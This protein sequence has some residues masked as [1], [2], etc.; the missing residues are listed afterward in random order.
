MRASTTHNTT[1]QILSTELANLTSTAAVNPPNLSNLRRNIRHQRQEQN[2]LLNPPRKEDAPVFPHEYQMTGTGERFFRFDSGAR[3]IYRMFI[4]ATNDGIDMLANS[5]QWFGDGTFKLWPQIFSQIYAIHALTNH[6][7]LPCVFGLLPSKAKIVYMQFF[8]TVCNTVRNNN[9]NDPEGFLVDFETASTNAIKNVLPQMD[10]SSCFF[11]LSSKFW[12]DKQRAGL[13]ERYMNDP[14][15]GL[16]LCVIAAL[17]FVPLQDV[18]NSFDALCIFIRNQYDRDTDE[19]LDYFENTYIGRFL[20]NAPRR[21]PLFPIELWNR[22]HR[23]AEELPRTNNNIE[24]W[25]NSLQANVSFTH[26]TFWK[27]L[28]VL[29]RK[30][31]IVQVKMLQNQAG[32]PPEPQRRRYAD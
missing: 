3:D 6:E 26:P 10:I 25:R 8:T 21:P 16:Q 32:H 5:S 17:A 1:Q 13:Q 31:S 20:R 29:L 24:A 14:E 30:E 23:T 4:F 11:H 28:G 18:V 22:F 15:F 12:K 9:S 27:F 19:V 7:V 2:I